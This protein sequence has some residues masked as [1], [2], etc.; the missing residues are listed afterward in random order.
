M[1]QCGLTTIKLESEKVSGLT[2]EFTFSCTLCNTKFK[3]QN[4]IQ[5]LNKMAVAGMMAAGCGNA[6]LNSNI[7]ICCIIPS[8]TNSFLLHGV[9][10]KKNG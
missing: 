1:F 2:S 10:N 8:L 3:L 6:N 5:R 4:S 7:N 9:L